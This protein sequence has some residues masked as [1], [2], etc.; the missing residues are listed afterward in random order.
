MKTFKHI[1]SL[2]TVVAMLLTMIMA[3]PVMAE[4]RLDVS[5]SLT[6]PEGEIKAG[7]SIAIPVVLS[8]RLGMK[9][10]AFR[11][12]WDPAYLSMSNSF[13]EDEDTGEKTYDAYTDKPALF[14]DQF[15][16]N[17]NNLANG[18]LTVIGS[19]KG[20]AYSSSSAN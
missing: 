15:T 17:L 13:V 19:K 9:G 6:A 1:C 16:I 20:S 2:L 14:N 3:T 5:I 8:D 4:D 7:D 10:A 11:I 18:E 12:K